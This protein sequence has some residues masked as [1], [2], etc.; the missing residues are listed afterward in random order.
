MI[1]Q[2]ALGEEGNTFACLIRN[3]EKHGV[4]V[5]QLFGELL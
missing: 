1:M 3:S 2:Q 4:F 5:V